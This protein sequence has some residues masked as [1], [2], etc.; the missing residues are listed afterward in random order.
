MKKVLFIM[1]AAAGIL[2]MAG[3]PNESTPTP[4]TSYSAGDSVE[5]TANL[6][7]FTMHYVPAGSTFVMG[8][9]VA[10]PPRPTQ[11][12][13]LTRNF[14]MG[15]TEVTQG[16][17]EKV[18][19][20]S[21]VDPWPGDGSHEPEDTHGKG[22]YYPAYYVSW[23]DAAAFC[24]LLTD[25][26][27]SIAG[28]EQVYYSDEELTTPYTK[29]NA[30]ESTPPAVYVDWSKKGYRLPTEAEWEYA[31]RYIDGSSW[32]GGDHVSGGPV[33]TNSLIGDYAWFFDTSS[34]STHPTG[35]LKPNALGLRDMNGNVYEW[36]YDYWADAY[37]GGSVTD[38]KGPESSSGRV[39]RGGDFSTFPAYLCCANRF[40]GDPSIR[41]FSLGFRLCR[42][43]DL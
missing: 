9:D 14:W 38:P 6:V 13:T 35:E 23:Y 32:N 5:H 36:C 40:Y 27:E 24:N 2:L 19:D 7:C 15:K 18:W 28:S 22:Y 39:V 11:D 8:E 10:T 12:V 29:A 41:P 31:A 33:H 4:V 3:C 25:A 17:W 34:N 20:P 30:L 16:L 21:G 37:S 43:A 42:T 26:D 1:A